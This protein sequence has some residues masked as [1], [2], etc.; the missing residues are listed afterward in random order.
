MPSIRE[1]RLEIVAELQTIADIKSAP[2]L[3]P[4]NEDMFPF[5]AA[6]AER[7]EFVQEPAGVLTGLIDYMLEIH[8][9]RLEIGE[10]YD[11]VED[12]L[13]KVAYQLNK[14]LN[15]GG[16]TKIST[17]QRITFFVRQSQWGSDATLAGVIIL[18][19]TKLMTSIT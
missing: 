8:M 18:E 3:L 4:E 11:A 1:G 16:F 7:G 9:Q 15:E 19:E 10:D 6:H 14:K 17:W 2:E 5:V 12:L 13:Q